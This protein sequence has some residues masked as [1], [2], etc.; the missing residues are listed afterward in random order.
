MET[1]CRTLGERIIERGGMYLAECAGPHGGQLHFYI[2]GRQV[3]M[4]WTA[5]TGARDQIFLRSTEYSVGD[6]EVLIDRIAAI[7]P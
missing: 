3:V 6:N 1:T 4:I 7:R 5:T 2:L